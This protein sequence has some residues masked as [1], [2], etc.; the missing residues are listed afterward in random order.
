MQLDHMNIY[1]KNIKKSRAFY[2]AVLCPFGFEVV[3]DF[4][5]LAVGFGDKNYAA[6]AI[7][8]EEKPIQPL[9]VAFRVD[10]RE[11]VHRFHE[12][13]LK[14]GGMDNGAAGLRPDYHEHYYGA[15]VRDLDGHNIEFVCHRP[16]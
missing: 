2:E 9:H 12:I 6:F 15:F 4:G 3:R 10:K 11:D 1:V 5:E 7:V 14:A 16:Y 8:R 13:A